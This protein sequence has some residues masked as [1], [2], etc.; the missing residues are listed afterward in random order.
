MIADFLICQ[1]A[2]TERLRIVSGELAILEV[3]RYVQQEQE[4]LALPRLAGRLHGIVQKLHAGAVGILGPGGGR[5][6]CGKRWGRHGFGKIPR[7]GRGDR[8]TLGSRL[9]L[10]RRW[11][12]LGQGQLHV[13]PG[14]E[15]IDR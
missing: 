3:S 15:S 11:Q 2:H 6:L 10:R 4:F 1:G 9:V 5:R 12:W 13:F 14:Q 7:R 8:P